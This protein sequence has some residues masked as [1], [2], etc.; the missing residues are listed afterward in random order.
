VDIPKTHRIEY[1]DSDSGRKKL[2]KTLSEK[3]KNLLEPM[4]T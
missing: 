2:L 3:L 4:E 1:D